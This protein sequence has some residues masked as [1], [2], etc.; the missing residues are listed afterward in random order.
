MI[1][2]LCDGLI[3]NLSTNKAPPAGEKTTRTEKRLTNHHSAAS[4]AFHNKLREIV[5]VPS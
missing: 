3:D 2:I 4:I 1:T 5:L